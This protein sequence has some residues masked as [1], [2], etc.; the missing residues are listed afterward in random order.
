MT[1]ED[2][3]WVA[4]KIAGVYYAAHGLMA[5]INFIASSFQRVGVGPASTM[6]LVST[7]MQLAIGAYLLLDG[8]A[9]MKLASRGDSGG[10]S[11][12]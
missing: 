2:L 8:A 5:A 9:V 1:R 11:R 3:L 12:Q 10:E 6:W 7:A 4:I